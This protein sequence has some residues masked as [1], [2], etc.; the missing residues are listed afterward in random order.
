MG[1]ET[2]CILFQTC[3]AA[4]SA[5][6]LLTLYTQQYMVGLSCTLQDF[7]I[8]GSLLWAQVPCLPEVTSSPCGIKPPLADS[9]H[10]RLETEEGAVVVTA[11]CHCLFPGWFPHLKP[12]EL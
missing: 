9:H 3:P 4:P 11:G 1:T 6:V 5:W 10:Y 8:L 2:H 7:S 12:R